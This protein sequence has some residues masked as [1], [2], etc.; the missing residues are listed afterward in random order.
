VRYVTAAAIFLA[1][2]FGFGSA[3]I[4][5]SRPA[6]PETSTLDLLIGA[7]VQLDP[8]VQHR[9]SPGR[10]ALSFL[11]LQPDARIDSLRL[12]PDEAAACEAEPRLGCPVSRGRG[13]VWLI[14]ASGR[15][16]YCPRVG[17]ASCPL[18]A[19]AG[20]ATI[21]DRDRAILG[22]EISG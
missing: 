2:L 5:S 18:F 10:A 17:S 13:P 19:R 11:H 22:F 20:Y 7:T 1:L 15:L 21:S 12:L 8:G 4:A 9:L 3:Q 16:R 14:Q 6:D